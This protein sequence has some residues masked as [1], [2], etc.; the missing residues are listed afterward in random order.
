MNRCP[1]CGWTLPAEGAACPRC[2][3]DLA[4]E[5]PASGEPE[6]ATSR[7]RGPATPPPTPAELAPLFPELEI[8]ALLG[9][10]GMGSVYRARQK[11]LGRQVALK[12]LHADLSADPVFAQRFLREAR[13]MARLAH[14]GIVAVYDF[15][16]SGGRCWLV[17]EYVE[18]VNLRALLKQHSLAPRQALTIVRC[19]C[20][21][22]QFAHD[23]G[24]VHRDIKPENVLVDPRGHVKIADFGL[25]KLIGEP[26]SVT[27]TDA[28]QVMGTPHYMAPEQLE[29]P[30]DVD[31][32]ADLYSLGVVFYEMLT[33]ELPLGRF[34]PPS[35]RV[36]VD[37]RLDEIVLKSL[38]RERERRY[39]Q[40]AEVKTDVET[41]EREPA[42]ARPGAR[43]HR[44][45]LRSGVY[46][47]RLEALLGSDRPTVWGWLSIFTAAWILCGMCFNRGA[48][49][50]TLLPLP[51]LSWLFV[52]MVALRTGVEARP[53]ERIGPWGTRMGA[54]ALL[55]TA[56][57]LATL[58]AAHVASWE[59]W[60]WGYVSSDQAPMAGLERW[61][62][63][64]PELLRRAGITP[65][66]GTATSD[67]R[68]E[69]DASHWLSNPYALFGLHPLLLAALAC[70]LFVAAGSIVARANARPARVWRVGLTSSLVLLLAPLVGL[71][72]LT[73]TLHGGVQNLE[74]IQESVACRGSAESLGQALY[75]ALVAGGL[76]VHAEHSASVV[77]RRS[78]AVLAGVHALAAGPASVFERWRVSWQGPR[79]IEPHVLFTV[80]SDAENGRAVILADG[81]LVDPVERSEH[82][83]SGRL[84]ALLRAACESS[85]SK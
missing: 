72:T 47:P 49:W 25:A 41:V 66:P 23:E 67:L 27:L 5:R 57:G 81:G 18:G 13:A 85:G 50:L 74:G 65:E 12:V 61:Q 20:S 69:S 64:V 29:R 62:G 75:G 32:R 26:A 77:D 55:L 45:R 76:Q 80:I 7:P 1:K 73:F 48:L 60:T 43:R 51:L 3:F 36:Q 59:R 84:Q 39:Q 68:L 70:A 82:D 40:A 53:E 42:Q 78:G 19:L 4:L 28:G 54:G 21:A 16:E 15:G 33:G 71:H 37:V 17:M 46:L 58:F 6:P 8:E 30:R 35:Q 22:L 10:G 34:A 2:L 44:V 14:P 9:E 24:V 11:R 83:W 31:H 79:R 63:A 38:E 52:S 56:L